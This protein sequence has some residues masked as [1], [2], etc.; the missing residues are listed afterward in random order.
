MSLDEPVP[1]KNIYAIREVHASTST[2]IFQECAGLMEA[3]KISDMAHVYYVRVAPH[4]VTSPIGM[5]AT[6]HVCSVIPNFLV[7]GWHWIDP[8]EL[9][10]GERLS[11]LH[12][13]PW[14]I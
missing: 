2:P 12:G 4:A 1:A 8:R 10:D 13:S 14:G 9:R 6:A 5:M 11:R 7:Q 3:R